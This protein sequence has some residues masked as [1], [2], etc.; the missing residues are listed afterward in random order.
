M[1][2]EEVRCDGRPGTS[3]KGCNIKAHGASIV[4]RGW[5]AYRAEDGK[6]YHICP[7]H[8]KVMNR[9][10]FTFAQWVSMIEG[11]EE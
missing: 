11:K 4:P 2:L 8:V 7:V 9:G 6:L 3:F 10:E 5:I 1:S